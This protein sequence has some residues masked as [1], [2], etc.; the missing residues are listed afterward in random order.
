MDYKIFCDE[1][2]T[3]SGPQ[4]M[5][6]GG[7]WVPSA[8]ETDLRNQITELRKRRG[9]YREFH[10]QKLSGG[11][12]DAY[13]EFLDLFFNLQTLKFNCIVIDKKNKDFTA[14][15]Q[16]D[17]EL[18][19]YKL[20]E[21]LIIGNTDPAHSYLLYVD[22]RTTRK[23]SRLID[24]QSAVNAHWQSKVDTNEAIIRVIEARDS[25]QEDIIQLADILLGALASAW[26]NS[27]TGQGKI[28]FHDY[29]M[30][31]LQWSSL[32]QTTVRATESQVNV[33]LLQKE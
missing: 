33:W 29:L 9:L 30:K 7:L 11:V 23:A 5:V 10:W 15:N 4:Y 27:A 28:I 3:H 26:N 32:R 21:K 22:H 17:K 18:G 19:F 24:L 13:Q 31:K 8:I 6:I 12:I 14:Y 16:G 25:K 1:S 20:Y 2:C